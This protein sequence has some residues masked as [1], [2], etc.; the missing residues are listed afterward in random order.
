MKGCH[1]GPD[2]VVPQGEPE[3]ECLYKSEYDDLP[4][5]PEGQETLS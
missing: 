2:G 3:G 4:N 1:A 5:L